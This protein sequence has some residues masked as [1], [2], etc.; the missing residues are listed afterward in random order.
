MILSE[1]AITE[2]SVADSATQPY[3]GVM[4]SKA[5][6]EALLPVLHTEWNRMLAKIRN[7]TLTG[8]ESW[9]VQKREEVIAYGLRQRELLGLEKINEK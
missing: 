3:N 4:D 2:R 8:T 1:L 6:A 9:S 7:G 5:H